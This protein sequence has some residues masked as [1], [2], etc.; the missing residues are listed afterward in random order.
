MKKMLINSKLLDINGFK[1]AKRDIQPIENSSYVKF[2]KD[3][4]GIK[5]K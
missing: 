3:A 5:P 2:M 1:N 4:Y